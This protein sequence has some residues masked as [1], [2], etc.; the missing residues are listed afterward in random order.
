MGHDLTFKLLAEGYLSISV[1][2]TQ[3][4]CLHSIPNWDG[5]KKKKGKL[6]FSPETSP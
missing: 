4:M 5:G 3:L 2:L 6:I 1:L